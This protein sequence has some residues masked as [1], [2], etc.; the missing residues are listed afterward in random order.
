[1]TDSS[2]NDYSLGAAY[3]DGRKTLTFGWSNA[4]GIN[5]RDRSTSTDHRLSGVTFI[6]AANTNTTC[7]TRGST[8]YFIVNLPNGAGMYSVTLAAGDQGG[9]TH[10]NFLICDGTVATALATFGSVTVA[11]TSFLDA[12][13][14]IYTAANWV[15]SQTPI[16]LTFTGTAMHLVPTS[17]SNPMVLAHVYLHQ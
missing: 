6:A 4:T 9:V 8:K 1:V 15:T 14:T 11:A 2:D 5:V 13:G 10:G 16:S 12:T 3:P 17:N 7:S